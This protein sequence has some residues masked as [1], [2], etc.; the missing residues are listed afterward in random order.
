MLKRVV[1]GRSFFVRTVAVLVGVCLLFGTFLVRMQPLLTK[2][3]ESKA[4]SV[5][6]KII[7]EQVNVFL[8]SQT[9]SYDSLI[10]IGY[11]DNGAISYV[12]TD[13]A[14]LNGFK[15]QIAAGIQT[16]FDTYDFGTIA[17]PLGTVVGGTYF[18]G[19]GPAFRFRVDM[20]CTVECTFQNLF[21]DAGINQ[22]R[23]QIM[24][25]IT[26]TTFAIARFC[27]TSSTVSTNF[28]IAETVIVGEV[29]QYYTNVEDSQNV[30]EDINNY[31][32]DYS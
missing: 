9:I 1:L 20:S 22:T 13:M 21:D 30:Q 26:A 8:Q 4:E 17:I 23:H 16:C 24:M 2:L 3:S 14:K 19:R 27:K 10:T 11:H 18:V 28:V 32:Y 29:P 7:H 12:A 31:G 5:T 25:Q 15:S 6:L